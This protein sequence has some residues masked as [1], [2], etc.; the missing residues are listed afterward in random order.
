NVN[1]NSAGNVRGVGIA[2][3]GEVQAFLDNGTVV[4]IGT[5]ALANFSNE[6]GLNRRGNNLYRATNDVGE[7]EVGLAGT[8]GRG[9]ILGSS[10]EAS[11]VDLAKEFIDVIRF[12][13]GYQA[14]SQVIT[15]IN[16]I[17]TSTINIA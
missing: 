4:T 17:L 10:L 15:T 8:G 9:D 1:G 13:R 7:I 5:L 16:D 11:T 3:D 14:G 2:K 6:Y 12:Q